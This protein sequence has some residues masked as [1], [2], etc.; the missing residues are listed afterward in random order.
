[1]DRKW[2]LNVIDQQIR[3]TTSDVISDCYA[4]VNKCW[5]SLVD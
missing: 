1:M 5:Y 2:Y 3:A 4:D